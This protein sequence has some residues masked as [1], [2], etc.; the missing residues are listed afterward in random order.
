M[1]MDTLINFSSC[2]DGWP[3]RG[4]GDVGS[5]SH[6]TFEGRQTEPR[7]SRARPQRNPRHPHLGQPAACQ[8]VPVPGDGER[9]RLRRPALR[10]GDVGVVQLA[11]R[12]QQRDDLPAVPVHL[13]ETRGDAGPSRGRDRRNATP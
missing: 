8:Q 7:L 2:H 12:R 11:Q 10:G 9:G 3:N 6:W 1:S 5:R 13:T 4:M